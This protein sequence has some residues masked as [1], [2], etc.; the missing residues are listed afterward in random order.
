MIEWGWMWPSQQCSC[1]K[2]STNKAQTLSEEERLRSSWKHL[3]KTI[4]RARTRTTSSFQHGFRLIEMSGNDF[5]AGTP[6]AF[7]LSVVLQ[8][9]AAVCWRLPAA[10]TEIL[11]EQSWVEQSWWEWRRGGAPSEHE[12]RVQ[13]DWSCLGRSA[14][15]EGGHPVSFSL[16]FIDPLTCIQLGSIEAPLLH[17]TIFILTLLYWHPTTSMHT[18]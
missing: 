15:L 10:M 4:K 14:C 18:L 8:A 3:I 9:A 5:S 16:L 17:S 13:T 7:R 11:V 2:S 6:G 12:L 1:S